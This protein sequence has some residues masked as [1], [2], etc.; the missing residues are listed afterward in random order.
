MHAKVLRGTR[1]RGGPAIPSFTI[2]SWD[3][4]VLF[5]CWEGTTFVLDDL[6]I[7]CASIM[8]VEDKKLDFTRLLVEVNAED[9]VPEHP[10]IGH[11]IGSQRPNQEPIS[12][13]H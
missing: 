7:F 11:N 3:F 4:P 8:R 1:R 10:K 9:G 5:C 13:G 2:P 6:D 12:L